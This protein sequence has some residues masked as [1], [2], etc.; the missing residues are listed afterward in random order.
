[1]KSKKKKKKSIKKQSTSKNKW[2]CQNSRIESCGH[3]NPIWGKTKKKFDFKRNRIL[4]D[5]IKKE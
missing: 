3:D 4:K 1:M 5:K 2:D